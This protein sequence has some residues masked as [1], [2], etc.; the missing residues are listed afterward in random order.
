MKSLKSLFISTY[1][2]VLGTGALVAIWM[3]WQ[4]FDWR[5]I[6]VL[7]SALPT[8]LFFAFLFFVRP[9]RTSA[10]LVWLQLLT[11]MG[12][13]FTAFANLELGASLLTLLWV[14]G[15]AVPGLYLYI[16]WYSR[17]RRR[18]LVEVGQPFPAIRLQQLD[19]SEIGLDHYRGAP[20]VV[21]FYRGNWCPLCMA[22]IREVAAQYQ[23]LE[24]LG[25]RVLLV[26]P[27][28]TSHSRELA[29]QF[30]VEFEFLVDRK[31]AA[32]QALGIIDR[33]N[34]PAGLEVL[35]YDSDTVMPTVY[36]LDASGTVLFA[37]LTDNYR[38]RP[39]PELFLQVLAQHGVSE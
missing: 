19:G 12:A 13:A 33:G 38:V 15:G 23:Q 39:E 25:A 29:T 21:M 4:Q 16:Y 10:G 22:Q 11:I 8:L 18:A 14:F 3:S 1:L 35:G 2:T 9:A 36:V 20:V 26:S 5:W 31:N 17:Y 30:G 6:G 34:T 32:A 27:Q 28:P 37:H 7:I 24:R